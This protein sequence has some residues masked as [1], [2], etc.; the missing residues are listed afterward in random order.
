[1]TIAGLMAKPKFSQGVIRT[2]DIKLDAPY[3]ELK[4][5]FG[6]IILL[7]LPQNLSSSIS[8]DWQNQS[9]ESWK[10][11]LMHNKDAI[12]SASMPSS[13]KEAFAKLSGA[14]SSMYN[15]ASADVQEIFARTKSSSKIGG[16]KVVQNPRNEMMFQGMQFRSFNFNFTLVPYNEKDSG[17][18]T[19]AIKEIQKAS[20]PELR[21]A[22]MFMQYPETWNIKFHDGDRRGNDH[23][24]KINECCCTGIDVNY[25]PQG[26][27]SSLHRMNAPLAVEL[28]LGFTEMFIPTKENIDE[29]HG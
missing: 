16:M 7:P 25:T 8:S 1:M 29:F 27:S 5:E 10:F 14:A 21:G 24:M 6:T 17:N 12:N 20:V 22:K 3:T 19:Q 23:L 28:T 18:I 11:Q 26:D 13:F 15:E 4:S 2:G 9:V